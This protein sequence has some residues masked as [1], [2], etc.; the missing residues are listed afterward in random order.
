ML[1]T[2]S[3]PIEDFGRKLDRWQ[4][5]Y[6]SYMNSTVI[7]SKVNFAPPSDEHNRASSQKILL[8][9]SRERSKRKWRF[10]N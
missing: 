2:R 1:K 3:N 6:L 10:K 8:R 5:Y 7:N 4:K 9:I